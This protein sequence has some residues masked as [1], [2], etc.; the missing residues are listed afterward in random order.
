MPTQDRIGRDNGGQLK[1]CLAAESMSLHGQ[2]PTLV[3]G[4]QHTLPAE[5]LQQGFDLSILEL[6][7][8]LLAFVDQPTEDGEH[9]VPRL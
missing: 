9:D 5:L 8:L 1:K 3:S 4:E 7:N 2:Q 6:D